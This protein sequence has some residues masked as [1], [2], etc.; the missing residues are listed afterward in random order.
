MEIKL[1]KGRWSVNGKT[2]KDLNESE[3]TILDNFIKEYKT[4]KLNLKQKNNQ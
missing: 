3:I 2:F 1:I 4:I